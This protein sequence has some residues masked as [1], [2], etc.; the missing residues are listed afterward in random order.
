[1]SRDTRNEYKRFQVSLFQFISHYSPEYFHNPIHTLIWHPVVWASCTKT[2][3]PSFHTHIDIP[4]QV[5][6]PPPP[7]DDSP[8]KYDR[9]LPHHY[10]GFTL[11]ESYKYSS[12]KL[13]LYLGCDEEGKTTL[14]TSLYP[15][16]YPNPQT[17][18]I[19]NRVG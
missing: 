6:T 18:F 2:D 16:E 1:M 11:F 3:L 17:L 19:V 5:Y 4:L 8:A 15:T 7:D 12:P 10:N 9:F 13:P 14:V